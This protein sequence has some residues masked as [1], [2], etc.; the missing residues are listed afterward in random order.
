MEPVDRCIAALCPEEPGRTPRFELEFQQAAKIV[1]RPIITGDLYK[2]LLEKGKKNKNINYNVK[3]LVELCYKLK[4][5]TIRLYAVPDMAEAV[6]L[7][8]KLALDM[9][10]IGSSDGTIG[11]PSKIEDLFVLFRKMKFDKHGLKE[12]CLE[13]IKRA[14]KSSKA[15][16]DAGAEAIVGRVDYSTTKGPFMS[17]GN[18]NEFVFSL[19]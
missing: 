10:V 7:A 3:I 4:Y 19:P 1:G 15:Q 8:K 18:F 16:I 5:D 6:K 12:E 17:P 2:E 11:M 9:M 13:R 14:M